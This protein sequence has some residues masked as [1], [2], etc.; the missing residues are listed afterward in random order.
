MKKRVIISILACVISLCAGLHIL[1]QC[2]CVSPNN[3][4]AY[5]VCQNC[6]SQTMNGTNAC[7]FTTSETGLYTQCNCVGA[8]WNCIKNGTQYGTIVTYSGNCDSQTKAC[9]TLCQ[10]TMSTSYYTVYAAAFCIGG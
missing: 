9:Q 10:G 3:T 5:A 8:Q 7:T 4:S 2:S 1:A 6:C